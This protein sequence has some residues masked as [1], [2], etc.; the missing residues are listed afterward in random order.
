M[1]TALPTKGTGRAAVPDSTQAMLQKNDRIRDRH[2]KDLLRL[3]SE[4]QRSNT[5]LEKQ[6]MLFCVNDRPTDM[7]FEQDNMAQW[8]SLWSCVQSLEC[9]IANFIRIPSI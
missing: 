2:I 7:L 5:D 8:L 6:V 3:G 9:A 1:L 4:A